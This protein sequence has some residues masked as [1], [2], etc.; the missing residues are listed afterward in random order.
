MELEY[1]GLISS[2]FVGCLL[3]LIA[4]AFLYCD[5]QELRRKNERLRKQ[6]KELAESKEPIR[7]FLIKA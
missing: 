4:V 2:L 3:A 6:N 7:N 5:N 1:I